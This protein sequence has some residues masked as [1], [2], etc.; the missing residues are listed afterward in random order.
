M[1][2]YIV[3]FYSSLLDLSLSLSLSL[4]Y[5]QFGLL[6]VAMYLRTAEI[7]PVKECIF[8][9]SKTSNLTGFNFSSDPNGLC[10]GCLNEKE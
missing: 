10:V 7:V 3:Q 2:T 6:C 1:Y 4:K 5:A 8:I 9:F